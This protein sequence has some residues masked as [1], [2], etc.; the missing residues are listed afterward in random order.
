MDIDTREQQLEKRLEK[1][2]EMEDE[3]IE[4]ER[5]LKSKESVKKQILLRLAPRLWDQIAAWADDDF[6]SI[7]SQIEYI[8]NEAIKN[9]YK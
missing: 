5:V 1:L 3:I 2:K 7:N 8:L 4:R 9:H 6:R